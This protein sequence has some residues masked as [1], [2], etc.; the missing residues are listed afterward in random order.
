MDTVFEITMPDRTPSAVWNGTHAAS[1][2]TNNRKATMIDR[3]VAR[4]RAL[5]HRAH[6][7]L[8]LERGYEAV[9]VEEIC[10]AADVGRS[11]FYAHYP[12]KEAL[13]RGGLDQLRQELTGHRAAGS[14]ADGDPLAFSLSMFEHAREHLDLYR[15]IAGG[16]AGV[17]A[18][19]EIRQIISEIVRAA[20][21]PAKAATQREFV[22]RYVVG[23]YLAVLTWWL[24]SG[25]KL[26]SAEM[27]AMFRRLAENGLQ[28]IRNLGD[29]TR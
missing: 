1:L 8:I 26:P 6:L 2:A 23:A 20:L 21:P 17:M 12:N 27:D 15:A 28:T 11:T 10:A 18:L 4:T 16:R 25:A 7:S 22:V 3:R 5:L 9:T 29:E 24:D 13:H 19:E 14:A